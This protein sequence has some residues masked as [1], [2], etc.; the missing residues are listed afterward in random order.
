MKEIIVDWINV[1]DE[2]PEDGL[3]VLTFCEFDNDELIINGKFYCNYGW[4]LGFN[5]NKNDKIKVVRW[6]EFVKNIGYD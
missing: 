3:N 1:K 5:D 2:L 4:I 6:R